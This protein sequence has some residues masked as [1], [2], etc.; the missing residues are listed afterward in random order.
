METAMSRLRFALLL[1]PFALLT[2]AFRQVPLVDPPPIAVPGK[3][4]SAQVEKVVK[5][6]LIKREWKI[7]NDAPGK[8]TATLA[9][10]DYSVSI[11]V[12][13][14]VREIRISY[15]DSTDLKYEVK[16]GQRFI[17]KNYPSWIQNLVTDIT[18]DLAITPSDARLVAEAAP[19]PEQTEAIRAALDAHL[20]SSL[21]DPASSIQYSAGEPTECRNV[22]TSTAVQLRDSWCVCYYVNAKNSMGGYT[23]AQLGV[24]SLIN[25]EPPFF[26]LDMP[27]E[28]INRPSGC[29]NVTPRDAAL[30]HALVK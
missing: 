12:A 6:A 29:K 16:N 13:Y 8:I 4:T 10:H 7:A 27:K 24:V 15:L 17:H 2:M 25:S 1:L 19:K 3:M 28:L 14:D 22:A 30:I 11:D 18:N 26:M 23:G 9:H 21:K 5:Q 20:A